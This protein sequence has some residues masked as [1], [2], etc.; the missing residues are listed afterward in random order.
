MLK[1]LTIWLPVGALGLAVGSVLA[2]CFLL[3]ADAV[4]AVHRPETPTDVGLAL[5]L[6]GHFAG[7][8]R[9]A[10]GGWVTR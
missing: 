3:L 6:A 2:I 4:T 5:L 8:A 9:A 10:R 1:A 7:T